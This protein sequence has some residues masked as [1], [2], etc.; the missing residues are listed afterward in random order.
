MEIG[1]YGTHE[2]K[3]IAEI[4]GHGNAV[5]VDPSSTDGTSEFTIPYIDPSISMKC[6]LVMNTFS[7]YD[8]SL[9]HI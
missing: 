6:A 5:I 9:I 8:L 7:I 2:V 1:K 3:I 4:T